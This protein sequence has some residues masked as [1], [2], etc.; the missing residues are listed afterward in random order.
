V[1][2]DVKSLDVNA[3]VQLS[4]PVLVPQ[5]G[6]ARSDSHLVQLFVEP[7][8]KRAKGAGKGAVDNV[9]V[10]LLSLLGPAGAIQA[11]LA[12]TKSVS[13]PTDSPSL[14]D[15]TPTKGKHSKEVAHLLK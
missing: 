10:D 4:V 6:K 3:E 7:P 5:E 13:S 12:S 8:P 11:A 1:P 9:G 15:G 14:P 2:V